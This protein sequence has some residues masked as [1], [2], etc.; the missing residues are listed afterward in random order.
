MHMPGK[1]SLFSSTLQTQ[2]TCLNGSS[3]SHCRS[4][5]S[6]KTVSRDVGRSGGRLVICERV[7]EGMTVE[8]WR[9]G[10]IDIHT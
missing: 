1:I 5:R 6:C 2:E 9:W 10:E 8:V 3:L 4:E 7:G